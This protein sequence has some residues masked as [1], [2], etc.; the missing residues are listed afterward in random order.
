[1][2][3]CDSELVKEDVTIVNGEAIDMFTD[4][5]I[6]L[7]EVNILLQEMS[8]CFPFRFQ[9]MTTRQVDIKRS[10]S[11]ICFILQTTIHAAIKQRSNLKLSSRKE[12]KWSEIIK[13]IPC[14]TLNGV[15][16]VRKKRF[17]KL[18]NM[19]FTEPFDDIRSSSSIIPIQ[20]V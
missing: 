2:R 12:M 5:I 13:Q 18:D 17:A 19:S 14:L 9:A 4:S 16:H 11:S 8:F 20:K 6:L 15:P 1:M 3:A 7:T 10:N